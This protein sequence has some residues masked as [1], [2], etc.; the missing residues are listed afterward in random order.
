MAGSIEE[1]RLRSCCGSGRRRIGLTPA[2][3]GESK[4][5]SIASELPVNAEDFKRCLKQLG[6]ICWGRAA[7]AFART[8]PVPP[9]LACRRSRLY[10]DHFANI[11]R[12]KVQHLVAPI[13]QD[14]SSHRQCESSRFF[15]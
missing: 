14:H 13:I 4:F 10:L 12:D 6:S 7:S 9:R 5:S 11:V 1:R 8:P 15:V 3:A 2:K